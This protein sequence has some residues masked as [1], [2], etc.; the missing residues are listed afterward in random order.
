MV[1]VDHRDGQAQ[2]VT[3]QNLQNKADRYYF[4][5][6]IKLPPGALYLSPL[7]LNSDHGQIETP[8]NPALRIA[9]PLADSQGNKRALLILNYRGAEM[10]GYVADVTEQAADHLMVVNLSGR[11]DKDMQTVMHHMEQSQQEKH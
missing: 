5:D 11:G 1:R 2:I 8:H 10:L 3:G 4:Q 6:S 9:M 7:D